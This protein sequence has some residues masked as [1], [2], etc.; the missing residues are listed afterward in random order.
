MAEEYY[1]KIAPGYDELYMAEQLQKMTSVIA[2]FGPDVPKRKET[3]LDVGCGTGIS[4]SVWNCEC[5][6]IDPSSELIEIAKKKYPNKNFVVGVA[7]KLPFPD[8]SFDIVTCVTAVHNFADVRKAFE[9]MKRVCKDRLV[10][11]LL[12]KSKKIEDIEKWVIINFKIKR[13]VMEE[14]DLIFVCGLRT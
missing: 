7:E 9:E 13:I 6:G 11:T 12:R 4:M 5:T 3:L 10:I 8:K 14:K 2:A 1:D